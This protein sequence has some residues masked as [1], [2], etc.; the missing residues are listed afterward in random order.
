MDRRQERV[1]GPCV[2]VWHVGVERQWEQL[3]ENMGD[4]LHRHRRQ[5]RDVV[6]TGIELGKHLLDDM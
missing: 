2:V 1:V 5:M 6:L 4:T 3:W